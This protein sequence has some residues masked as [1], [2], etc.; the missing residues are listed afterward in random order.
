M[1]SPAWAN[2]SFT[3][4]QAIRDMASLTSYGQSLRY[5]YVIHMKYGWAHQP[6]PIPNV[7]N[8]YS[9]AKNSASCTYYELI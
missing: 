2:I 6:W 1:V 3:Y 5:L 9:P 7:L 8:F 4:L